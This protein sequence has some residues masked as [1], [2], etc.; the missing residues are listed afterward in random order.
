MQQDEKRSGERRIDPKAPH[1]YFG[2]TETDIGPWTLGEIQKYRNTQ[3]S[4]ICGGH[5]RHK[6][7]N[8]LSEHRQVRFEKEKNLTYS[9]DTDNMQ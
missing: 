9:C 2:E 8:K 1:I 4:Q 3:T 5:S 7:K 6:T